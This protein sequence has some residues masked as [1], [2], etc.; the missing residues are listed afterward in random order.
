MFL[1]YNLKVKHVSIDQNQIWL[2]TV[3]SLFCFLAKLS[4][5]MTQSVKIAVHAACPDTP[6]KRTPELVF[7]LKIFNIV[8][9]KKLD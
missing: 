4:V 3:I 8:G 9:R 6:A 5:T 7:G 1:V 2:E